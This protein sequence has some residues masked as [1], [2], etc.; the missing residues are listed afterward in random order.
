MILLCLTQSGAVLCRKTWS[1]SLQPPS[2]LLATLLASSCLRETLFGL[3]LERQLPARFGSCPSP[4]TKSSV[5]HCFSSVCLEKQTKLREK[6]Y[7]QLWSMSVSNFFSPDQNRGLKKS[8][9]PHLH[10]GK[11]CFPAIISGFLFPLSLTVILPTK[12]K[13]TINKSVTTLYGFF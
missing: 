8:F 5:T 2:L 10:Q 4:P 1:S 11:D 6:S 12:M 9:H 7:F 3:S 13:V